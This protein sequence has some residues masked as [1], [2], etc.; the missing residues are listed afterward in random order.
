[1]IYTKVELK[2]V[3]QYVSKLPHCLKNS[4]LSLRREETIEKRQ[5]FQ[6]I[7]SIDTYHSKSKVS[8]LNTESALSRS[9]RRIPCFLSSSSG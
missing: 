1:M 2:I 8:R 9:H 3:K 5:V 4:L 7:V 6:T